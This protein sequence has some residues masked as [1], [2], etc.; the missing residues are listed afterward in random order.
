[1][2]SRSNILVAFLGLIS[3]YAAP[4][5]AVSSTFVPPPAGITL[6][7]LSVDGGNLAVGAN[8][9]FLEDGG[10]LD[11]D[12]STFNAH[13]DTSVSFYQ[14]HAC[15]VTVQVTYPAG[16]S[17]YVH[18]PEFDGNGTVD[19]PGIADLYSYTYFGPR[20]SDTR[21]MDTDQANLTVAFTGDYSA[22]ATSN[23]T[24]LWHAPCGGSAN[25]TLITELRALGGIP[26]VANPFPATVDINHKR[27]SYEVAWTSC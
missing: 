27:T 24:R 23:N 15:K 3:I 6:K 2:P 1:M 12:Y 22:V 8:A 9:T 13:T 10:T 16:F 7:V 20:L 19:S 26:T 4:L 25:L 14:D 17:F 18:D 21:Q 5:E 11:L